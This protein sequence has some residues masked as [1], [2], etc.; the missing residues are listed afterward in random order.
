VRYPRS[1]IYAAILIAGYAWVNGAGATAPDRE[2]IANKNRV[3]SVPFIA[4][5]GQTDERVAFYA[6]TFG[7]TV[8]V[9]TAGEI[10]YSLP[11]A[12]ESGDY[13][14]IGIAL[15]ETLVGRK[16]SLVRGEG[17]AVTRVSDF[18]GR[19]RSRWRSGLPTYNA[20]NLGEVYDGIE[21]RLQARGNNVEKIFHVKP[22]AR[23]G[24]IDLRIDGGRG[25]SVNKRGELEVA[26]ALGPASFTKP[27]AFQEIDGRR[28]EVNARYVLRGDDGYGLEVGDYD[29]GYPLVI[30]PLLGSMFV[31]GSGLDRAYAIAIERVALD[32][33]PAVFIAGWT[34]SAVL[35]LAWGERYEADLSDVDEALVAKLDGDL[36]SVLAVMF[37]GGSGAEEAWGIAVD[38]EGHVYVTGFTAS[39]DFPTTSGAAHEAYIGGS[40]DAFVAKLDNRLETIEASTYLGGPG[41][42][43][44]QAIAAS[45]FGAYVT[46]YTDGMEATLIPCC[47]E[48]ERPGC[49]YVLH[50]DA[51]V[52]RIGRDLT[53]VYDVVRLGGIQDDQAFAISVGGTDLAYGDKPLVAITG[54]TKYPGG[55]ATPEAFYPTTSDAY[56]RF[57]SNGKDAFVTVLS[58][59]FAFLHASTFL[60]GDVWAASGSVCGRAVVIDASN[61]VYVAGQTV[62]ADF[63]TSDLA[64]DRTH[65]D[66]YVEGN[67]VCGLNWNMRPEGEGRGDAFVVKMTGLQGNPYDLTTLATSTLLGGCGADIAM[68]LALDGAGNVHVAGYTYSSDFP[69]TDSAYYPNHSGRADAFISKLDGDLTVLLASTFL[70]GSEFDAAMGLA[71]DGLGNTFV[72]GYT[73]SSDFPSTDLVLDPAGGSDAFV[74]NPSRNWAVPISQHFSNVSATVAPIL[75]INPAQ[76][77]PIGIGPIAKGGNTCRLTVA[78]APLSGPAD[79]YLGIYMPDITPADIYILQPD[80]TFRSYMEGIV[81]WKENIIRPVDENLFGEIPTSQLSPGT[82][83]L[84][85]AI[86]P[87][88]QGL[89]GGYYLWAMTFEIN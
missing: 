49:C 19:D 52:L 16:P 83:Y 20:V 82:Y 6:H 78:T 40:T 74:A 68:A 33:A 27:V 55:N 58:W 54:C 23:P 21:L 89:T 14:V 25:L 63:P 9:T 85:L 30:D 4:N 31:G 69:T 7:G 11:S 65:N 53:E 73:Y 67:P 50:Q 77:I 13:G 36:T 44:A 46:G 26:T 3:A 81:P 56:D 43:R 29:L 18:H 51:F 37:L 70:G 61:N 80:L 5:Q 2:G 75:N 59:D 42:D 47:A 88:G 32:R 72:A 87:T 12:K 17:Q 48:H 62:S 66:R 22:G 10:V 79:M 28:V 45:R 15:R 39:N 34:T 41:L 24:S 8:F 71:L 57:Q 1:W 84:Y 60:G 64:Y 86:A 38:E 35:P 76:A